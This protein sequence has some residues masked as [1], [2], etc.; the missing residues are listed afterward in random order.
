MSR[1]ERT[2]QIDPALTT[3]RDQQQIVWFL[4]V[5]TTPPE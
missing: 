4:C 2:F 3:K 1:L 5:F